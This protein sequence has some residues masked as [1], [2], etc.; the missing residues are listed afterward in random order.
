MSVAANGTCIVCVSKGM[1]SFQTSRQSMEFLERLESKSVLLL[2]YL[3]SLL[4][5][6]TNRIRDIST[7]GISI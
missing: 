6:F 1:K 2:V 7:D 3:S 4:S 5:A